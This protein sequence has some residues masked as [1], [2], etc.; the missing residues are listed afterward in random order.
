M[1]HIFLTYD[2][3]ALVSDVQKRNCNLTPAGN[4]ER[5]TRVAGSL[6]ALGEEGRDL[7]KAISAIDAS[8]NEHDA[9][10]RF[11]YELRRYTS[12][13]DTYQP[14]TCCDERF[15]SA[16]LEA[17]RL[18]G[19]DPDNY[20]S[21]EPVKAT[22]ITGAVKKKLGVK[23]PD[24]PRLY[25]IP[26]HYYLPFERYDAT[27]LRLS[28][29]L[30]PL[31]RKFDD[32]DIMKVLH[33]YHVGLR[34]HMEDIA[35]RQAEY[36]RV[37]FPYI[38]EWGAVRSAK[39]ICYG[40][41]GHRIKRTPYKQRTDR[42]KEWNRLM[43]DYLNPPGSVS[44]SWFH[45]Y[46]KKELPNDWQLWLCPFGLHL[47]PASD[48]P[49]AIVESEK[50]AL[51]CAL[52]YPQYTWIATGGE[53]FLESFAS[54]YATTLSTDR[55]G[56]TRQVMIFP[57]NDG[58]DEWQQV[59]KVIFGRAS[60]KVVDWRKGYESQLQKTSDIADLIMMQSP[61]RE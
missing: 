53:S 44:P 16:L 10:S 45:A 20:R 57:D 28:W 24:D 50:S 1:Q 5:W 61:D 38:D 34:L 51:I 52:K 12:K 35:K 46:I 29:F 31:R 41:D 55:K 58:F 6:A 27:Q 42:S 30:T 22:P 3:T 19:I 7:F 56:R 33:M 14:A 26:A 47:L 2:L 60:S 49:V 25:T 36:P 32:E 59:S 17:C 48:K 39:S 43:K 11:S 9:D 21:T 18:S 23:H 37:W 13:F 8:Y 54:D 4:F 15:I 40:V